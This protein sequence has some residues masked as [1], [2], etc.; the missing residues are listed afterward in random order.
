MI[1]LALDCG[2]FS[3]QNPF[4]QAV[5]DRPSRRSATTKRPDDGTPIIITGVMHVIRGSEA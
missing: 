1:E 2:S 5:S 3:V 4:F